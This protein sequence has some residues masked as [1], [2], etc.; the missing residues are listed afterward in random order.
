MLRINRLWLGITG[1]SFV[2]LAGC[3]PKMTMQ[4][5]KEMMSQKPPRPAELDKLDV[6][7]G[8]WEGTGEMTVPDVEGKLT[9]SMSSSAAWDVDNRC[10]VEHFQGDMEG[11]PFKG[12]GIWWWDADAKTYQSFWFEDNGQANRGEGTYDESTKT[13]Q[14]EGKGRDP[15]SGQ[16]LRFEGAMRMPDANTMEWTHVAKGMW[17]TV[18]EMKGTSKRKG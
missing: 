16:T 15:M 14:F 13:W 17:G 3:G 18:M 4:Q 1:F 6:F 9:F 2:A 8:T 5:V 11:T 10:V 12:I 7:V